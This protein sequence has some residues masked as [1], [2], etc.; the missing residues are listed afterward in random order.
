MTLARVEPDHKV[1]TI[2]VHTYLCEK[3]GLLE[4]IKEQQ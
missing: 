2:R 3:C 1:L 4:K